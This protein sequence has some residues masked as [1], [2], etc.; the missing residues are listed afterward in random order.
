MYRPSRIRYAIIA[1]T[2]PIIGFLMFSINMGLW[3]FPQFYEAAL[4]N[5]L[6]H[7]LQH[8]MFAA[9]AS[10]YWWIIIDPIPR[11]HRLPELWAIGSIF[12]SMM[13]GSVIGAILTLSNTILYPFYEHVTN[14]WGWSPLL[15]QQIGGLFMWAGGFVLYFIPA[16]ILVVQFVKK[17]EETADTASVPVRSSV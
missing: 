17:D 9:F 5:D 7:H 12:L 16:I 1:I 13:I 2:G 10:V 4:N 6:I 11:H 3:H 14:P 8:L 15:D